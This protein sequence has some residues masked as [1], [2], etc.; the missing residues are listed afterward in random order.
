MLTLNKAK[1]A[2]NSINTGAILPLSGPALTGC[3]R[4]LQTPSAALPCFFLADAVH[5]RGSDGYQ[6]VLWSISYFHV[7]REQVKSKSQVP[8]KVETKPTPNTNTT[9][10]K[11]NRGRHPEQKNAILGT[12]SISFTMTWQFL[13]VESVS[14]GSKLE[15]VV[16]LHHPS[17]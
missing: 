11:K 2:Q 5:A 17:C 14:S 6:N 9:Q 4:K 12:L 7:P 13:Q 15:K 8:S 10:T 1:L 16:V 3:L